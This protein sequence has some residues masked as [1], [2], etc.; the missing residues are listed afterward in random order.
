MQSNRTVV[1]VDIA[2]RVFQ[3]HWGRRP[4]SCPPVRSYSFVVFGDACPAIR[5]AC[6]SVP[7]FDRYAVM[8]VARNV[9]QHVDAGSPAA[10]ARRLDHG[11]HGPARERPRA[12]L[13]RPVD[14]LKQRRLRVLA[15]AGGEIRLDRLLGSVVRRHVVPLAALLVQP[16]PPPLPLPKVNPAAASPPPRS[17]AR[18]CTPARSAAPGPA[19]PPP[20]PCRSGRGAPVSPPAGVSTGVA[21]F[22]TTCFGPRT[23][24]AGF[25]G[26]LV[27]D[28]PAAEHP[29]GREAARCC[30]RA[31]H[32]ARNRPAARRPARRRRSP[33]ATRRCHAGRSSAARRARPAPRGGTRRACGTF[34]E[35]AEGVTAGADAVRKS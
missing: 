27:D 7:P 32:H 21:P 25:G 22:V 13:A 26:H 2:K 1:G 10:A 28:Q 15:A 19:A 12:Q 20:S 33:R 6:S 11:Q 14:A 35:L 31:A 18:S 17:P 3:L 29:D 24:T 9:W 23:D 5:C 34:P 8:P 30:F 16:Q 4:R